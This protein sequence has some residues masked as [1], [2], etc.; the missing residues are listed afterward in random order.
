VSLSPAIVALVLAALA[1]AAV[2]LAA[3]PFAWRVVRRWDLSSAGAGQIQLERRTYL[4]STAVALVLVV[5]LASL[6]LFVA[7]AERMASQFVGAMCAVG[8]L[9]AAPGGFTT[10]NLHLA[11]FLIAGVWLVMHQVDR[12]AWDYP[13]T[14]A[15]YALLLALAPLLAAKAAALLVYLS[16][17]DADV[18]SSCC[19]SLFSVDAETVAADLAGLPPGPAMAA[20][21]AVMGVT[22]ALGLVYARGR[23]GAL[24]FA[25]AAAVA[26][27]TALAAVVSFISLYVYEHPHH[28]C[29]FCLLQ[30]GYDYLGY[31]LYGPLLAATVLALG[32]G[33]T[34]PFRHAPGLAPVFPA[35]ARRLALWSAGLF[36]LFTAVATWAVASSNLILLGGP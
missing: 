18:I 6:V 27:V 17:L 13:L 36:A 34:H 14:R 30:G 24:P 21:Y 26:F 31:A 35:L 3:A 11:T 15:K 7:N 32:L 23:R 16:G 12:Q 19:G 2:V 4:V 9:N 29:P 22:V 10:L 28:H 1:T 20:F 8:T 5:E 25:A 33:A